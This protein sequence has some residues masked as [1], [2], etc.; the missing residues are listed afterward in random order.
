[1]SITEHVNGLIAAPLTGYHSDGSVNLDAPARYAEMLN[2][3]GV[4]GAF[5]NGTTGEG[6]SLTVG[7]RRELAERA[8]RA[9]E[10][11]VRVG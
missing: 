7:E 5:V 6:M 1:M 4:A 2:A 11:M 10:R 3:N 9:V 8:R